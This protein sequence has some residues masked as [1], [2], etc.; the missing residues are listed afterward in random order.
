[1]KHLRLFEAFDDEKYTEQEHR[2]V[3]TMMFCGR[4]HIKDYIIKDDE[5]VDVNNNVILNNF[6]IDKLPFK[7]NIVGGNFNC[8]YNRLKSLKGCPKEVGGS[9]YCNNNKLISLENGPE[10]VNDAYY[11]NGNRLTTLKGAPKNINM[12]FTCNFNQLT[13]LEYAPEN[14]RGYFECSNNKLTSL[15]GCPN[16]DSDLY[17]RDN[18]ITSLKGCPKIINGTFNCINN[19]LTS[20]KD[21]PEYVRG[22]VYCHNNKIK[23]FENLPKHIG[24]EFCCNENP[25]H[26][27]WKLFEDKSK[28]ELFNDMDIIQDDTII[29]DRLNYFLE[30]IGKP[31]V[32]PVGT[33]DEFALVGY[34]YI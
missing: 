21:G 18:Q 12:F 25:I 13:S 2:K 23:S 16:I 9:F 15:E 32:K 30:E 29:I 26:H 7:F 8:S 4:Y 34:K 28:I 1:M 27:I 31:T 24:G 10:I 20:L 3:N 5:T 22:S 33:C 14:I 6:G 11:C 17:F 19:K